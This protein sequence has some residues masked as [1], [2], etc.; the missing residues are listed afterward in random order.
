MRVSLNFSN[1]NDGNFVVFCRLVYERMKGN[2]AFP[3]LPV[4]LE[5][6]L[7][8]IVQFEAAMIDALDSKKAIAVRNKIREKLVKMVRQLGHYVEGVAEDAAAVYSAG[9]DLA[10]KTRQ[11]GRPL[12]GTTIRKVERGPNSGTL[13]VSIRPIPRSAGKV[14]FYELRHA[15][16]GTDG[17][18]GEWTVLQPTVTA[19]WPVPVPN[20]KPGTLD[21]FQVRAIGILGFTDWSDSFTFMCT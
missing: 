18:D 19:R 1:M 11:P 17:L 7:A 16:M 13:A 5:I 3:K 10:Y 21:A 4:D 14:K 9:F 2:P 15:P 8:T 6:F 20:L 12:P